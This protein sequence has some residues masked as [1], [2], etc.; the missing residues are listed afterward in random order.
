MGASRFFQLLFFALFLG[1]Y[2]A[3]AIVVLSLALRDLVTEA[4]QEWRERKS[5]SIERGQ[6]PGGLLALFL[7]KQNGGRREKHKDSGSGVPPKLLSAS[8]SRVAR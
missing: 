7:V 4:V 6:E 1:G 5:W 3:L 2:A 8:G